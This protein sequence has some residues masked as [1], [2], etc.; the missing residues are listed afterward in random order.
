MTLFADRVLKGLP[1]VARDRADVSEVDHLVASRLSGSD[2]VHLEPVDPTLS[3]II[4]PGVGNRLY[5]W[6]EV[7]KSTHRGRELGAR[8]DLLPIHHA[9][10]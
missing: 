3:G 1:E 7:L 10:A 2:A 4:A 8:D 5:P 6:A 9:G